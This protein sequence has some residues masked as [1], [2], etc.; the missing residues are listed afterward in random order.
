MIGNINIGA[1]D[2]AT[3]RIFYDAILAP[4]GYT[5]EAFDDGLEYTLPHEPKAVDIYICRPFNEAPAT[6]GNGMMVAFQ[7]ARQAQV[8]E[9][10]AAGL[11]AGGTDEGQPGFR[12]TYSPE[13]YVGYLR[14]PQG[15]KIAVFSAN[16]DEPGRDD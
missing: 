8:H 7:A 14:D 12:P 10:H 16:P 13:F 3:A 2:V 6:A 4:L 9:L 5:V 1:D 15:N 11:A